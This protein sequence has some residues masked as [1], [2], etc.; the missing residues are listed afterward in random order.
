MSYPMETVELIPA[1]LWTCPNCGRE[2]FE[3]CVVLERPGKEV[4][5]VMNDAGLNPLETLILSD[6]GT[7]ECP[8]CEL[9]YNTIGYGQGDDDDDSEI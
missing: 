2:R 5:D 3:R 4:V 1:H 6:P 7:V 8:D 9:T